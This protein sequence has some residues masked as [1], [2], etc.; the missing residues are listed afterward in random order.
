MGACLS[1]D[2]RWLLWRT[3]YF[4]KCNWPNQRKAHYKRSS[5]VAKTTNWKSPFLEPGHC[6]RQQISLFHL[7]ERA[8][9]FWKTHV[10]SEC[11]YQNTEGTIQVYKLKVETEKLDADLLNLETPYLL[12]QLNRMLSANA[13][14]C[15]SFLGSLE[16]VHLSTFH[17]RKIQPKLTAEAESYQQTTN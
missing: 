15:A 9:V 17:E 13:G 8:P 14:K 1:L 6:S 5:R 16:N 10:F 7:Y 12:W 4:L 2:H 3:H 11:E